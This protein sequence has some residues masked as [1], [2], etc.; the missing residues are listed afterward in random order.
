M[1]EPLTPLHFQQYLQRIGVQQ[2]VVPVTFQSLC[3]LQHAHLFNVPFEALDIHCNIPIVLSPGAFYDKIVTRRRGGYCYEL[4]GLFHQLLT[5][6]GFAPVM[7]SARV[8]NAETDLI[9]KEFDHLVLIVS[10]EGHDWMVDVGFGDFALRPLCMNDQVQYDGR[11]YYRFASKTYEGIEYQSVEKWNT[12]KEE[13]VIENLFTT[14]PRVLLDFEEM[15]QYQQKD[16]ASH[17]VQNLICT[18]PT[19][20]GRISIINSSFKTTFAGQKTET[21]VKN[22]QERNDILSRH[23]GIHIPAAAQ[24]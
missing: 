16:P 22:D 17:F 3:M 21:E 9:G 5:H 18:M 23:F 4:N 1:T 15:N 10:L 19:T 2:D 20:E 12:E 14:T 11:N 24:V 8:Y 6:L 7:I 13:F